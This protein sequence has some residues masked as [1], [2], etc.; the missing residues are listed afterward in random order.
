MIPS[1]R[2]RCTWSAASGARWRW[3][4]SRVNPEHS[5]AIQALGVAAYGVFCAAFAAA[6]FG[7]IRAT[8]GLRVS[9]EEEIRGLDLGEHGMEAYPDFQGFLTK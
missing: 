7:I 4:C 3:G 9:R 8:M 1:V 6:A 5:I 2:S